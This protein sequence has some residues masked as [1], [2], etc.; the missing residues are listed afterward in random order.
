MW[1]ES[2]VIIEQYVLFRSIG[3]GVCVCVGGGCWVGVGVGVCVCVCVCREVF[4][5]VYV[6]IEYCINCYLSF[7]FTCRCSVK[8]VT[9]KTTVSVKTLYYCESFVIFNYQIILFV[10]LNV[11]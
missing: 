4:V 6:C 10:V 2:A 8:W 3:T 5:C 1:S 7:F 9:E 11:K